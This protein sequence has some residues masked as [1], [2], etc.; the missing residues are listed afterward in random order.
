[1]T[2]GMYIAI[3]YIVAAIII[4]RINFRVMIDVEKLARL[5]KE[6]DAT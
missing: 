4:S 5:L 2:D 1:M 3:G 6:K